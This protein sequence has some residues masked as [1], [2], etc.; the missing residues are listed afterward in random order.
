MSTE[1]SLREGVSWMVR[2]ARRAALPWRILLALKS[3]GIWSARA[4]QRKCTLAEDRSCRAVRRA[5][6]SLQEHGV[7]VVAGPRGFFLAVKEMHFAKYWN[8]LKDTEL[9]VWERGA[10]VR[11]NWEEFEKA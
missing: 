1:T 2:Q 7:P 8:R 11:R 5:V 9:G 4:L 3:G 6:R 10:T